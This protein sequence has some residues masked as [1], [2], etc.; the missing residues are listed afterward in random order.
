MF[1][2]MM[3]NV[4]SVWMTKRYNPPNE[5]G[6]EFNSKVLSG[7]KSCTFWCQVTPSC[8]YYEYEKLDDESGKVNCTLMVD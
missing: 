5:I 1:E 2:T 4:G 7:G 8:R 3:R 6:K